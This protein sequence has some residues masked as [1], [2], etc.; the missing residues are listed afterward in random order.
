[1]SNHLDLIGIP[2]PK[3]HSAFKNS[4]KIK[5]LAF[6]IES[7]V[8][9]SHDLDDVL[10]LVTATLR[11]EE[12]IELSVKITGGIFGLL[13]STLGQSA[14]L[15]YVRCFNGSTGRTQLNPSNV[16]LSQ[17]QIDLH[18]SFD[19]IRDKFIAH[20]E[21]NANRHHLFVLPS[22]D[23]HRPTLN[24][25]GQ[26]SRLIFSS[27]IDW[28]IFI[29]LVQI[30]QQYVNRRIQEMCSAV[31]NLLTPEQII[32]INSIDVEKARQSHLNDTREA[33]LNP[34]KSRLSGA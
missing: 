14:L 21:S 2:F 33:A 1:M 13:N 25:S 7:L 23:G 15:L 19:E 28:G 4:N 24:P 22:K 17:D 18:K 9:I 6:Q 31:S 29:G 26:T 11:L 16:F 12:D 5:H 20:Q 8:E 3:D 30:T 10:G 34:L 27:V 32:A